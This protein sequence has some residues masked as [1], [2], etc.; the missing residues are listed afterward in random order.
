MA[1]SLLLFALVPVIGP[2]KACATFLVSSRLESLTPT[3]PVPAVIS[4]GKFFL[5]G[6]TKVRGPGQKSLINFKPKGGILSTTTIRSSSLP[7]RS[8]IGFPSSRPLIATRRSNA[9]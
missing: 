2:P 1:G 7:K 3:V 6:R 8:N 9:F 4:F 5:A